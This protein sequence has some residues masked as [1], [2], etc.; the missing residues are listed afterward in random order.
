MKTQVAIITTALTIGIGGLFFAHASSST[1]LTLE[2]RVSTLEAR[3]QALEAKLGSPAP[4]VGVTKP[5]VV[6][7]TP[8]HKKEV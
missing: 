5:S 4:E 6:N 3:L 1:T 2:E 7:V 8:E